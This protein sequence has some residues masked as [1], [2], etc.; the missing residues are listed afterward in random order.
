[1]A[2]YGTFN[3]TTIGYSHI[4]KGIGCEDYSARLDD[5]DIHIAVVSD[6]HGDKACFRSHLGSEWV[7]KIAV[8]NLHAF[9]K[10]IQQQGW[11]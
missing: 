1:M 4:Q 9:A 7:T 11:E 3:C 6:G 2:Q 10:N 8:E 5:G